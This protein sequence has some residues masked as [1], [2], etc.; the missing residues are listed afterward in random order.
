MASHAGPATMIARINATSS[1]QRRRSTSSACMIAICPAGPPNPIQPSSSQKRNTV[2]KSGRG[3]AAWIP[4]PIPAGV[5][6]GVPGQGGSSAGVVT[7]D[8]HPRP[9]AHRF[10]AAAR[11]RVVFLHVT[12]E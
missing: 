5:S 2:R 9:G 11:P 6:A 8:P 12:A 10:A 7:S 3:G 4:A 1:I